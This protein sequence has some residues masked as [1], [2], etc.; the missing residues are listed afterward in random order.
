MDKSHQFTNDLRGTDTVASSLQMH[1]FDCGSQCKI[2][3]KSWCISE[4]TCHILMIM[5]FSHITG[6]QKKETYTFW[7]SN[8]N[9]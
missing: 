8:F 4:H 7:P 6:H 2:Q 9:I 3:H 1:L 5:N